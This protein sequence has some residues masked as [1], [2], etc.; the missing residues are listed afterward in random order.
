METMM[1]YFHARDELDL[2]LLIVNGLLSS[3]IF[4]V[5][6][7]GRSDAASRANPL[8]WHERGLRFV[9]VSAYGILAVR[10][11]AG[12]YYTPVEP[13]HVAVNAMMLACVVI[14]RG[15]VSVIA[16]AL[17]EARA[18]RRLDKPEGSGR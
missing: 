6:L 12:W 8:R 4:G 11:W 1:H 10:V 3:A 5:L 13:T 2:G 17:R 9:L 18:A 16:N 15:D 7:F 14:V